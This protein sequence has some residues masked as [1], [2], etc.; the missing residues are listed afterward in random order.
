MA[1]Q[2]PLARFG[3]STAAARNLFIP[4]SVT[5]APGGITTALAATGES[6]T[7]TLLLTAAAAVFTLAE[8]LHATI[9]WELALALA[10]DTAQGAYLGGHHRPGG[11]GHLQARSSP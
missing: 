7:A 1:L 8:M 6:V 3:T 2:V 4:L 5:F 9:S 10:L 11:R